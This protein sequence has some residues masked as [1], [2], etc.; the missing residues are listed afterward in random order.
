MKT[1]AGPPR[2]R[3]ICLYAAPLA[4]ALLGAVG[5]AGRAASVT[6]PPASAP[7][8]DIRDIRGPQPVA[9]SWL[10]PAL[11]GAGVAVAVVAYG[12]VRRRRRR[13]AVPELTPHA[14]ALQRLDA[15]RAAM[16]ALGVTAFAVAASDVIRQYIEVRFRVAVTRRTTEEFLA[17]LLTSADATLV[18]HRDL[19]AEFLR[20]CDY[21][22]FA[23]GAAQ[24]D[25]VDGLYQGSRSFVLAT[26]P[27]ESHDS[28]PAA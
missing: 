11:L 3:L 6:P 5:T 18:R 21:A 13:A 12:V 26:V 14:A 4:A 9:S 8:E 10:L 7:A 24:P 19:L 16:P 23:G 17:D 25:S 15:L 22:K 20:R 1:P 28:I 27:E 2:V